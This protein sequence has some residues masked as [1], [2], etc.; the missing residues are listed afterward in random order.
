V[1]D[2]PYDYMRFEGTI[3][4]GNYGAGKV[5]VWDIGDYWEE[6]GGTRKENEEALRAGLAKG[7][8]SIFL[9]GKKLKGL[10]SLIKMHGRGE[11]AWLLVKKHDEYASEED[12]TR[13]NKTAIS[14]RV[15][16]DITRSGA[17]AGSSASSRGA[18]AKR[19]AAS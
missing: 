16:E 7:H 13:K 4:E 8:L 10:F 12:V 14:S 17:K 6:H 15:L 2:H 9:Q 3:P 5:I 18:A 1:E 11:N 19:G